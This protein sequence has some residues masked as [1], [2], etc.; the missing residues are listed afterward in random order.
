MLSVG[1]TVLNIAEVVL[2]EEAV[3]EGAFEVA[4]AVLNTLVFTIF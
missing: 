1:P 3:L 2:D 4:N